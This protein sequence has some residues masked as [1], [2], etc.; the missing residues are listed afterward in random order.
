MRRETDKQI[1]RQDAS[2]GP[3]GVALKMRYPVFV[4]FISTGVIL[5][6]LYRRFGGRMESKMNKCRLREWKISDAKD[7]ARILSNHKILD[8]LRDGIPYP[9]TEKDG[10]EYIKRMLLSDKNTTF[11]FAIDVNGTAVGSIAAF[12]Q[13]NIHDRTAEI[14]YYLSEDY[15]NL[16]IMTEAVKQ[17][18]RY[19]F[20][21]TNIIR[22]FAEPFSDNSAS[23]RVLEK[24]GF[25]I[26]GLLRSNAVKNGRVL[27][28]KMYSLVTEERND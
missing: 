7:I 13:E 11:A 18:C 5:C 16:G 8:N 22:I 27:D 21:Y 12:R 3:G 28:M 10:E 19:L 14:G 4:S 15:W 26:E 20:E 24:A 1:C 6:C 17:L 25:H 9:Y 2:H 23:C